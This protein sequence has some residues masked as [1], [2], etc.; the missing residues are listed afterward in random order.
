MAKKKQKGKEILKR[1]LKTKKV[2]Y[3]IDRE[4]DIEIISKEVFKSI[5]KIIRYPFWPNSGTQKYFSIKTI[6]YDGFTEPL[7]RGF[8]K[9]Y[10]KGYGFTRELNPLLYYLNNTFPQ[11]TTVVVSKK[12]ESQFKGRKQIV[13]NINDLNKAIPQISFMVSVHKDE[14]NA[15]AN[16]IFAKIFPEK[17]TLKAPKYKKG[18]LNAFISQHSLKSKD[19]SNEDFES[20]SLLFS[21]L[22][23]THE[24]IKKRGILSTK[25]SVDRIFIED[26]LE[27]FNEL[28]ARKTGSKNLENNWQEFFRDNILYFNFGYLECFEK[29]RIQGDKTINIPDFIL[30]NTHRYLDVFEIKTHLTQL[31]SFDK[32]R[33]NFYWTSEASKAISQAENYIDSIIKEEDTIIK[34]IRDEY[35]IQMVNAVRPSVYIIASSEIHIA[36]EN[37]NA[38][39][40]GKQRS[41]LKNDFRRLND[42]LKNIKFVLYDELLEGF[43]NTLKRL[44]VSD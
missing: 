39:Y 44:T 12:T 7:P 33:G 13:F 14:R 27:R 25:E 5:S 11:I 32:G 31:M 4:N 41:K 9:S 21:T 8:Y 10:T 6:I 18:Q 3:Y 38:K 23:S 16:N 35:G 30:L 42:A 1:N 40:K 34:N 29:E 2:F 26:I 43:K 20:I 37:T 24:F 19:L 17:F 15:L 28:L 36:G 22:P